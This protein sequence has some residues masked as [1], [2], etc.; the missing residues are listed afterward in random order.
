MVSLADAMKFL[1]SIVLFLREEKLQNAEILQ[2][3]TH[4]QKKTNTK[5]VEDSLTISDD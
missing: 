3:H 4:T 2:S 5:T 1:R